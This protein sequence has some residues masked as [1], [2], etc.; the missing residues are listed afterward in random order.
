M[1]RRRSSGTCRGLMP[2]AS[3]ATI[4]SL[5]SGV[6][7]LQTAAHPVSVPR[8]TA[9]ALW[10]VA[11][12]PGCGASPKA[13]ACFSVRP[14]HAGCTGASQ[15]RLQ[16]GHPATGAAGWSR[17][18][19]PTRGRP[20][21]RRRRSQSTGRKAASHRPQTPCSTPPVQ[22]W[23]SLSDTSQRSCQARPG[24]TVWPWLGPP[25]HPSQLSG[26]V[27]VQPGAPPE[28]WQQAG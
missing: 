20:R 11:L 26:Q 4:Y 7:R 22:R 25:H 16:A 9:N 2:S 10:T 21:R 1:W 24:A 17:R 5:K 14:R 12:V 27:F 18:R 8:S 6:P 19:R 13:S 23:P 15:Q 28:G 3:S